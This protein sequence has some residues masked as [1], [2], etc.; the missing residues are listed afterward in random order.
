[1]TL[2]LAIDRLS[3]PEHKLMRHV[4]HWR[5][6]RWVRWW[7]R[8]TTW[9]GDG[10]LWGAIGVAVLLSP[11]PM[12]FRALESAACAIAA[13]I[14]IFHGVKRR[15]RRKRPRDIEPHNWAHVTTRDQFS[16]PSGHA[17]TAFAV[18]LSLGCFFPGMMPVLLI[19]AANVA[20]SRVVS[21]MHFVSDV[22]VGS[23]VGALLGY[24]A[25]RVASLHFDT[26]HFALSRLALLQ[27]ASCMLGIV[28]ICCTRIV[29]AGT[30]KNLAPWP[31]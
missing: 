22:V 11:E 23:G 13:G 27:I 16:F 18:A 30:S 28:K 26:H 24:A 21:G 19:L 10:W 2:A 31:L 17:T 8:L 14:L 1:M 5:A 9:A 7:M 4:S 12:R 20:I 29:P 6:P 3:R 25:F 15:V